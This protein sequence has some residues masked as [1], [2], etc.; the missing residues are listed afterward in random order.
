MFTFYQVGGC[1]RDKLLGREPNDIDYTVVCNDTSNLSANDAFQQMKKYLIDNNYVIFQTKQETFTI[2]AKIAN[3]KEVADFVLAR[4][5][6]YTQDSRIPI[7]EIGTLKDD[8]LRRDFTVNA[9][10]MDEKG[11]IIDLFNG[12]KDL[13]NKKLKTP[14]DPK[15]TMFDDPLRII[16]ALRFSITLGFEIDE[17]IFRSITPDILD[18]LKKVVSEERIRNELYKMMA[19]DTVRSIKLF[20]EIEG[21]IPGILS[22]IFE[23]G[24]WLKP[25][26]EK[27]AQ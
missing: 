12:R 20:S 14:L 3:T 21:K 16:R 24:L 4:K 26:L 18:K 22:N 19:Y 7:V 1:V 25:T 2:R 10:A 13:E 6:Y 23:G 8:L 11:N 17:E 27:K 5:E 15:I 9:M